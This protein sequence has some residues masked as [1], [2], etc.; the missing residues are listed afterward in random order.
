MASNVYCH[1]EH[2]R[3]PSTDFSNKGG[4]VVHVRNLPEAAPCHTIFGDE[5]KGSEGAW[6]SPGTWHGPAG[7]GSWRRSRGG[8]NR[9]GTGK[10]SRT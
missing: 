9:K 3:F 8:E 6:R 2:D 10:K 5:V 7:F 1:W 4:V